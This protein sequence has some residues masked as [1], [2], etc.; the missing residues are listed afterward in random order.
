MFLLKFIL[1]STIFLRMVS[2]HEFFPPLNSFDVNNLIHEVKKCFLK[3][4]SAFKKHIW[5]KYG[6]F[7][8]LANQNPK[9]EIQRRTVS[10]YFNKVRSFSLVKS[11]KA[12]WIRKKNPSRRQ[13]CLHL[14]NEYVISVKSN[15]ILSSASNS[16]E[17]FS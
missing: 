7:V 17:Y 3:R 6:T 15:A 9:V 13:G 11:W 4:I 1:H 16:K 10:N 2:S 5:S 12:L 14:G 8:F